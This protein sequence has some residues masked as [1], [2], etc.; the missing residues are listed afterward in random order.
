MRLIRNTDTTLR[1]YILGELRE[2]PRLEIEERLITDPATFEALGV[3]EQEL[4][5]E[6]LDDTLSAA[7]KQRFE[8]HYLIDRNR[9]RQLD[10]IRLLKSYAANAPR[11]SHAAESSDWRRIGGLVRFHPAWAGAAAAVI[12]LLIGGNLWFVMENYTL[13]RQFDQVRAQQGQLQ[14]QVAGLTAQANTLQTR[15]ESQRT[16]GQLPTFVLTPG[17]LRG[18]GTLA[19]IAVSPGVPLVRLELQIPGNASPTYRAVLYDS[20]GEDTWSQSKLKAESIS[21]RAVVVV[22]LPAQVLSRGDY[23]IRLT[24]TSVRGAL[25]VTATYTFRVNAL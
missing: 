11:R 17:Q 10:V 24:G 9:H 18:L 15:L 20:D 22:M 4:A 5:E 12:L 23:R 7:D 16:P 1:Q 13:Q 6:Y 3:A 21:G 25:E 8:H 19:P 2:R 14:G